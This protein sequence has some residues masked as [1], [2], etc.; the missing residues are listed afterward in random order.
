MSPRLP[1]AIVRVSLTAALWACGADA[2]AQQPRDPRVAGAEGTA[3]I[4][5]LVLSADRAPKPLRRAVVTLTGGELTV[6]RTGITA[7]DGGFMFDRLPA[8]RYMVA[9]SKDGYVPLQFGSTRVFHAGTRIAVAAGEQRKIV[10]GLPRGAVI[11]GTLSA[12]DG[13][14][15]PGVMVRTMGYRYL[16]PPGERRLVPFGQPS[17]TDDRGVYRIFGL[18]AGEF[19]V[20]AHLRQRGPV[21]GEL[22]EV[23]PS[24]VRRAL[25]EV[26]DVTRRDRPGPP[27]PPAALPPAAT[28]K[29]RT[30]GF[31]PAFYP[32]TGT[33]ARARLVPVAAGEER[34]GIDFSVDYVQT[35]RVE[36][37]VTLPDPPQ[38]VSITLAGQS[39]VGVGEGSRS[40]RARPDGRFEFAGVPPGAYRVGARAGSTWASTEINVNGDDVVISL[41]L[42]PGLTVSGRVVFEGA[43]DTPTGVAAL[44]LPLPPALVNGTMVSLPSV[45][46]EMDGRFTMRGIMPGPYRFLGALQGVRTSIGPWWLTS[47]TIRGREVMDAPL[48][49]RENVDDAV[50]TFVDRTNELAGSVRGWDRESPSGGYTVVFSVD[51]TRWFHNSR[52]I[53]AVRP[54]TDGRYSVKNLPPGNYLVAVVTDADNGEWFDPPFL[55]QLARRAAP[56][57]IGPY[58]TKSLDLT[59]PK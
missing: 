45:Q 2:S 31:A 20:A 24:D 35:A 48:D 53:A 10:L 18:P 54:G 52:A 6:G 55:E 36:G 3:R 59:L 1:G 8:G 44:R 11:T 26:R 7:D 21:D 15:L 9:A 42:Q 46:L 37:F 51:R 28:E 38:P 19:V 41:S 14:P 12:L 25:A 49:V 22:Q 47:M 50:I 43:S 58:E 56:V 29:R 34:S 30:L 57:A 17:T 32:G 33:V 23:S 27:A 40:T 5:G 13:Q 16:S 39:E 4:S